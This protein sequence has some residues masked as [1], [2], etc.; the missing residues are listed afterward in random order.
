MPVV[1][2]DEVQAI[3]ARVR[4]RMG[5]AAPAAPA[6][7]PAPPSAAGAP[8]SAPRSANTGADGVYATVDQAVTAAGAAYQRFREAGLAARYTIVD[9]MRRAMREHGTALAKMA[10]EE[11][12]LGRFEDKIIKNRLVNEKT[13]GPEDLEPQVVT[14][15]RGL[16]IT[17]WAP[18]GVIASIAPT[19]NPTSTI[20]NNSIAILAAGNAVVFN[21]HP[22]AKRVSAENVRLLHR[23]IVA[24]GGPDRPTSSPRSKSPPSK[25]R[26][27]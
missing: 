11:T 17:E 18:F 10:H 20:I 8:A 12:G 27:R 7:A 26:A 22:N 24:A 6:N 21:A 1:R 16:T 25:P 13:P 2:Q 15:D 5:V 23:A 14:G 9:A 4:E 19:T 3:L